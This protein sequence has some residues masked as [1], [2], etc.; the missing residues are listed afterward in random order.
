[1]IGLDAGR[2]TTILG[3]VGEVVT[4]IPTI[5]FRVETVEYENLIFTVWDVRA[6]DRI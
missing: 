1:M 2:E 4:T 6:Q 5:D 3:K